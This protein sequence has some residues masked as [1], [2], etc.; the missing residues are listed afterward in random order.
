MKFERLD[1][2]TQNFIG[3][4]GDHAASMYGWLKKLLELERARASEE[5]L[6]LRTNKGPE[7]FL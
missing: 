5:I 3:S 6:K 4:S 2:L 1:R 7:Y